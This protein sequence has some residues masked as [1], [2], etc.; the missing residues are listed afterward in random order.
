LD[1]FGALM[2]SATGMQIT[3]LK[4]TVRFHGVSNMRD[5]AIGPYDN[6]DVSCYNCNCATMVI[7]EIRM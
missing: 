7:G 2:R 1:V 5:I 3:L 4:A 6:F